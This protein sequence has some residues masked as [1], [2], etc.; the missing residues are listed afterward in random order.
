MPVLTTGRASVVIGR[1]RASRARP[2]LVLVETPPP[3]TKARMEDQFV[4]TSHCCTADACATRHGL[5]EF[6]LLPLVS[7]CLSSVRQGVPVC[8]R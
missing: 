6:P 5:T 7:W 1:R 3:V 2:R 8:S 4:V